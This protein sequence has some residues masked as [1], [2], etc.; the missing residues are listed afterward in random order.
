M[1]LKHTFTVT[2]TWGSVWAQNTVG[3]HGAEGG[4]EKSMCSRDWP[5]QGDVRGLEPAPFIV[6]ETLSET[7]EWWP[8]RDLPVFI[9]PSVPPSFCFLEIL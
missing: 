5:S 3:D 4:R 7:P 2:G 8:A 9:T 1:W 6:C